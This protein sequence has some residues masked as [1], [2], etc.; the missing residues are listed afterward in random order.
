M[1]K[2]NINKF[3]IIVKTDPDIDSL[4]MYPSFVPEML[5]DS[6]YK[7]L[8]KGYLKEGKIIFNG[9]NFPHPYMFDFYEEKNGG[10]DKFFID[11]GVTE[12]SLSFK[13]N[14]GEIN[15]S[16]TFKSITQKE[17]EELKKLGL[18][19]V[20]KLLKKKKNLKTGHI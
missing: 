7:A 8:Y 13:P 17:Y 5:L 15:I 10:T 16:D 11:N 6:S 20:N 19:E 4:S 18:D 3:S 2:K 14:K 1:K 12:L 9:E